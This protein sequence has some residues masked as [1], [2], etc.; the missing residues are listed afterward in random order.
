LS[1][2]LS[3]AAGTTITIPYNSVS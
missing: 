3:V 1:A 2:L